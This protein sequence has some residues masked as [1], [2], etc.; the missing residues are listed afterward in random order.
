[1]GRNTVAIAIITAVATAVVTTLAN[2]LVPDVY[3]WI[4]SSLRPEP[5]PILLRIYP[6]EDQPVLVISR[7]GD[8][9]LQ[10]L[11]YR[12]GPALGYAVLAGHEKEGTHPVYDMFCRRGSC[13][14]L[15]R[16]HF[17]TTNSEPPGRPGWRNLKE[18]A[19]FYN[20]T[21]GEECSAGQ[22]AVFRFSTK[23]EGGVTQHVVGAKNPGNWETSE[24][25][26]C[27]GNPPPP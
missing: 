24:A 19:R 21:S 12:T 10:N 20:F 18:I 17:Y 26:G 16:N 14:G 22:F 11:D 15:V 13:G 2:V 9:E 4:K 1:M 7:D 8:T 27:L 23:T 6:A 25:L 3:N 5:P